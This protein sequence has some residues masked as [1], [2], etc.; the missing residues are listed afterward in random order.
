MD[1]LKYL[2]CAY[3][4]ADPDVIPALVEMVKEETTFG[5]NNF[6]VAIF[7]LLLRRK[8]HVIVLST[9]AVSVLVNTLASPGNANLVTDS[10]DILVALVES[11]EGA[12][13]L[14]RV[15]ALPLVAKILQ[16]ATSRSGEE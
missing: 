16:S 2:G 9:G 13:A 10:L 12:Y 4:D 7:G 5:K 3:I 1:S 8:N 6:V 15:E 14:L 11:V